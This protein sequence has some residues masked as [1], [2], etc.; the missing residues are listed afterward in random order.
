MKN[1]NNDITLFSFFWFE[2]AA[3][4]KLCFNLR[5][6]AHPPQIVEFKEGPNTGVLLGIVIPYLRA[7]LRR[8]SSASTAPEAEGKENRTESLRA[9]SLEL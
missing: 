7:N 8:S 2:K 1:K 4:D 3:K 5:Q 9:R 6:W